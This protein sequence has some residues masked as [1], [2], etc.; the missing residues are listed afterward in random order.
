MAAIENSLPAL[1]S[2]LTSSLSS[3]ADILP[4]QTLPLHHGIS[5]LDVKNELMLAYL[6]NIAFLILYKIRNTAKPRLRKAKADRNDIQTQDQ[7]L[8]DEAV[9]KLVE[10]R[11]YLERGVRPLEVRLKYQV[12]KVLRTADDAAR[13]EAQKANGA[14]KPKPSAN[15]TAHGDEDQSDEADENSEEEEDSES[16]SSSSDADNTTGGAPLDDL[17]YRP[18]PSSF[19]QPQQAPSQPPTL[20]KSNNSDSTS[21]R[22]IPPK[23]TPTTLDTRSR[24]TSRRPPRSTAID[25][26]IASD[27]SS[28]PL[29]EPSI[30]ADAAQTSRATSLG[31]RQVSGRERETLAERTRYEEENLVRLPKEGKKERARRMRGAEGGGERGRLQFGGEEFRELGEG[32]GRIER[33]VGRRKEKERDGLGG[34]LGRSRKREREREREGGAEGWGQGGRGVRPGEFFERKMKKR[35]R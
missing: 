34:A 21:T 4:E 15:G 20:R 35:R 22:Y 28:A 24:P 10:L 12:D 32:A 13:Q 8:E 26:F 7:S 6:Q 5:L 14:S 31:R 23:I 2:Q 29:A 25:T 3:A 9:K 11:V 16:D 33:L 18:N 19:L 1:I 17:A 27:L 30:G